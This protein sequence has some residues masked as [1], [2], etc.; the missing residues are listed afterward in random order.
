MT[1]VYRDKWGNEYVSVP[2]PTHEVTH[3]VPLDARLVRRRADR[4]TTVPFYNGLD[5]A[6]LATQP[7][8]HRRR[9]S[10]AQWGAFHEYARVVER[11][12]SE[13]APV[14]SAVVIKQS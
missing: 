11:E 4:K 14:A 6:E 5:G 7:R 1:V 3:A 13:T 9:W 8:T 10:D 12:S 2:L